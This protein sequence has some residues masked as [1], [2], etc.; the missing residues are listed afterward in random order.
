M[1]TQRFQPKASKGAYSWAELFPEKIEH[2][3]GVIVLVKT[4]VVVLRRGTLV[5]PAKLNKN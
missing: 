3:R 2:P 1:A 5:R 4:R